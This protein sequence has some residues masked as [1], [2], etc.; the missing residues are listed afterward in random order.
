MTGNRAPSLAAAI[1]LTGAVAMGQSGGA[2]APADELV[3]TAIERNRDFLA[4]RERLAESQALLRQAGVRPT[5]TLEVEGGTGRPLGT[6]GEEEYSAGYF[7]PIETFGKRDK[8]IRIAQKSVELAEAEIGERRRQLAFEIKTRHA[9]AVAEQRKIEALERLVTVHRESY[10]LTEVRARAGDA[11]VLE[12]RLLSTEMNRAEAQKAVASGRLASLLLE[13]RQLAGL[14]AADQLT[15]SDR[16]APAPSAYELPLREQALKTRPD[17]RIA[18]LLEQQAETETELAEAQAHPDLT[19][20]ARYSRRYSQFDQ[21]GLNASGSTV[22]LRDR[23]NV[24]S[25]G[26]AIPLFT[27]RRN[28]GNIDAARSRVDAARLRRQH[29]EATIPLEVEAAFQRWSAAK[30]YLD[31]LNRGVIEQSERNLAVIRQAYELGQLRVLDVLNEQRRLI[32]TQLAYIDAQA[33]QFRAM[34]ELEK[35]VGGEIQ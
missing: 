31:I 10:R 4:L 2:V 16:L 3:R 23:D 29:L 7:H 34:A 18:R 5:P 33:E 14:T 17:L 1:L 26:V 6:V 8:R 15:V 9:D 32:E 13:L 28:Q 27:R 35:A 21:L 11:A 30:R 25:F 19:L 12:A 24:V 20:S 22:P